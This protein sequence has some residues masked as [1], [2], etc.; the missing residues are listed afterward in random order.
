MEPERGDSRGS[1]ALTLLGL[2]WFF[3]MVLLVIFASYQLREP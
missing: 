2:V 1:T 3:G